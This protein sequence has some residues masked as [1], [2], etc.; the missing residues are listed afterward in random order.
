MP[1]KAGDPIHWFRARHPTRIFKG[2]YLRPRGRLRAEIELTLED[3]RTITQVAHVETIE[4]AR[5][6]RMAYAIYE[7]AGQRDVYA[8]QPKNGIPA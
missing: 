2:V 8:V 6:D 4:P 5:A 3:G 7:P 1:L